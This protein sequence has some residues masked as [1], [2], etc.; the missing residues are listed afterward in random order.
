MLIER[1]EGNETRFSFLRAPAPNPPPQ[2]LKGLGSII[3]AATT[4]SSTIIVDRSTEDETRTYAPNKFEGGHN[5]PLDSDAQ[6]RIYDTRIHEPNGSERRSVPRVPLPRGHALHKYKIEEVVG[7]GGFALTYLAVELTLGRAVAIKELFMSQVTARHGVKDLYLIRGDQ[8][9]EKYGWFKF[10]FSR[11]AQITLGLRHDGIVRMY[12]FFRTNNTAYIVYEFLQGET[13]H[14]WCK[15]NQHHLSQAEV[16]R[17]IEHSSRAIAYMHREGIVHRDIKP[18]NIILER[19]SMTPVLIDFG[20]AIDIA[21]EGVSSM[22]LVTSGYSPPEQYAVEEGPRQ[23]ERS[24]IYSYC[25]TL[26]WMLSGERPQEAIKRLRQDDLVPIHKKIEQHSLR[27][28]D[29]AMRLCAVLVL[30]PALDM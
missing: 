13:M 22:S 6:T 5:R 19:A 28:V 7:E 10:Y 12:E 18:E 4:D 14:E 16:M 3:A 25:A 30:I 15:R 23:D 24:D 8:D 20:A 9:A 2:I 29:F 11:E 26:Y 1:T 21:H 27:V 17:F